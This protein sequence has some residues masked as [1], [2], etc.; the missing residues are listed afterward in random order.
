MARHGSAWLV[1]AWPGAARPGMARVDLDG[2]PI[3]RWAFRRDWRQQR[4]GSAQVGSGKF[5]LGAAWCGKAGHG[6]GRFAAAIH[7]E[8]FECDN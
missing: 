6:M 5:R 4:L 1:R 8:I 2:L 7:Q 3:N